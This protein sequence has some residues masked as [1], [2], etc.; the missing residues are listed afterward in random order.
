[1]KIPFGLVFGALMS[2]AAVGYA[3][4]AAAQDGLYVEGKAPSGETVKVMIKSRPTFKYPR[5]AQRLGVEGFVVLAFDVNEQGELI[6][7]RVTESKPRLV[8]DKAATQYIKKFKF[9]PASLDGSVVYASDISMR[10]PFRLE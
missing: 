1:M 7:L 10:M 2:L 8:F 4:P 3:S 6:D 5:R 9:Q